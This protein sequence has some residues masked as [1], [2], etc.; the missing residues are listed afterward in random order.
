[1]NTAYFSMEIGFHE[2]IPSYSGGLGILAG[3]TLKAAADLK[4]EMVGVTILYKNGYFKQKIDSAGRQ[5]EE[6][7]TWNISKY[8][9][10]TGVTGTLTINEHEVAYKVWRYDLTSQ[11]NHNIPIFFL[12]TDLPQNH[13]MDRDISDSL[14]STIP[15]LRLNQSIL[16]GIGGVDALYKLGYNKIDNYH[17]N[18]THPWPVILELKKKSVDTNEVKSKVIFTTHTPLIGGHEHYSRSILQSTLPQEYFNLIPEDLYKDEVLNTAILCLENSKYANAVALKHQEISQKMYPSYTINAVTNGV[19]AGSWTS[20][21]LSTVFDNYIPTWRSNAL[22]LRQVVRIPS[23]KITEAHTK[24]KKRLISLVNQ[25]ISNPNHH[26]TESK[27][28]IGF[29][30]RAASYKRHSLILKDLD[31]LHQIAEKF[32]GIQIVFAG[33]AYPTDE[34]G[35]QLIQDI[36]SLNQN[37]PESI[38]IVFLS[39]YGI[40]LSHI[41]TSGVDLWLNTPTPPLEAS[42]TSGMKAALNGVPNFSILDGWWIEGCVEGITGWSIGAGLENDEQ[43]DVESLYYKLENTILPCFYYD[44]ADWSNIR[45]NSVSINASYF[46]THRMLMEY[47]TDGYSKA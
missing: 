20:D 5:T 26:F 29:A 6:D 15:Q 21:E 39:D 42:G 9:T 23:E 36:I 41:I 34:L 17:L 19:H 22:D 37:T 11:Q 47:L 32:G 24:S 28:T 1:M 25:S 10:E 14:Y 33:K 43:N 30:R 38:N 7:E 13:Q 2:D 40:K 4:I 44:K 35:K 31:R 27:F 8:L 45:R 18:E 16:L 12:D 3:D 46:N